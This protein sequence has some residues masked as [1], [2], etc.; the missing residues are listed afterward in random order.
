MWGMG[1]VRRYT[2]DGVLDRGIRVPAPHV[3][4]VAFAGPD[5][6]TLVI[7]TATQDQTEEQ[8]AGHSALGKALHRAARHSRVSLR[9]AW[10]HP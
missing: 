5:L 10:R 7:T 9:R 2:P 8:L 4:S 3:S 6:D 1:E